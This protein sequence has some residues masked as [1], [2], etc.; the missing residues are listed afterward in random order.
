MALLAAGFGCKNPD[1]ELAPAFVP[2]TYNFEGQIDT[3]FV[4]TWKTSDGNSTIDLDPKG[5]CKIDTII[6]SMSGKTTS[7]VDGKWLA[8]DGSLMFQYG[9]ASHGTTV[10]KYNATLKGNTL[11]LQQAGGRMKTTYHRK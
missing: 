3:K 4:G 9:D 1:D 11:D 10:L 8:T 5:A 2:K 7:R 6:H